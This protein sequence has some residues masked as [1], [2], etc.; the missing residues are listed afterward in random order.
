MSDLLILDS[1]GRV[2]TACERSEHAGGPTI[3]AGT[4]PGGMGS[5]L[6]SHMRRLIV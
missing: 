1:Y 2:G 3:P 4:R 6:G 5:R